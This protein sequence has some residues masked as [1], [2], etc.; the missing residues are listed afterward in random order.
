M[1]N[2][3]AVDWGGS[4]IETGLVTPQ[5]QVLYNARLDLPGN[6]D[7]DAAYITRAIDQEVK[8]LK[9]ACP[10]HGAKKVGI[11]IPGY[12]NPETRFL[13][14]NGAGIYDWAIG[15]ELDT[16][17]GM[18]V[19]VE[20]DVNACALAEKLF[21]CCKDTTDFIWIT[22]SSG[23]GGGL[24]LNNKLYRGANLFAGEIGHIRLEYDDPNPVSEDGVL[25]DM[26]NEAAGNAIGRK[27]LRL[28]GREPDPNFKSREVGQ[29]ARQG[30]PLAQKLFYQAGFYLAQM[31]AISANIL[32]LSKVVLGGGMA[33]Y[34]FDLM[35]Q[36]LF[37]NLPAL[38]HFTNKGLV[39]EKTALGYYTS[40]L[41]AA[42]IALGPREYM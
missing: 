41:G 8:K 20:K 2:V 19:V 32:N 14:S 42:A 34:D 6:Y 40:M 17:L 18:P 39:I 25:G 33:V 16:V 11:S 21:G 4:K 24:F 5:G 23:C 31:C 28:A 13:I 36:G 10:D 15:D 3:I 26:E 1:S 22:L 9:D 12:V 37:D 30:D 29:L 38:L 35:E 7:Y 27:Y